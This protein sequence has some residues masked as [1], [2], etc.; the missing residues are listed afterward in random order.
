[1]YKKYWSCKQQK[2]Y[3]EVFVSR[4]IPKEVQDV[5]VS[6]INTLDRNYGTNRNLSDDGGY[7]VLLLLDKDTD[8]KS[9][10]NCILE[11][12]HMQR[13]WCEFHDKIYTNSRETYY[14]DLFIVNSEYSITIIWNEMG[15]YK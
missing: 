6:T 7:I 11:E 9:A 13:D 1:M 3:E 14:S 4:K 8:I 5:F 2:D 12:Y 10:Y 15:E